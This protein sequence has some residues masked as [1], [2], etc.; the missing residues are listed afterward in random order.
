MRFRR[1]LAT[2]IAALAI[3]LTIYVTDRS[4]HAQ[5]RPAP[6]PIR[7][8]VLDGGTL[9][10][11]THLALSHYHWD[12]TANASLFPRATWIVRQI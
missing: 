9:E 11:V 3:A 4:V 2:L 5:G 10:D 8:Y 12:H 1:T 7:L 6:V